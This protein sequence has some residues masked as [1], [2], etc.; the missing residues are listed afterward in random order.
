VEHELFTEVRTAQLSDLAHV[1]LNK[2][3]RCQ[4]INTSLEE[5]NSIILGEFWTAATNLPA[6]LI[7][8]YIPSQKHCNRTHML[9]NNTIHKLHQNTEQGWPKRGSST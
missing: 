5:Y 9:T 1:P 3:Q 4:K 8:Q 2:L 7:C 6:F